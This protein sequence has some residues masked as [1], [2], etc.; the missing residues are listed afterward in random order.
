MSDLQERWDTLLAQEPKLRIRNAAA[1]LETSE[2]QLL[3]LRLGEGVTRLEPRWTD[4]LSELPKLGSVMA[5]T[6]NE[7]AVHEKTGQYDN[8][9]VAG[10]V[11]LVLNH[12]I[13]LRIFL[14]HWRYGFVVHNPDAKGKARDSLQFFN[15]AGQALHKIF[16]TKDS[17]REA[18]AQIK[19]AFTQEDQSCPEFTAPAAPPAEKP[20]AELDVEGFIQAWYALEDTHDFFGLLRKYGVSRTQALTLA[21]DDLA[22]E[23]ETS[24]VRSMLE[25]AAEK[26]VP[27]MAFVGSPGVIQIHTGPI[28]RLLETGPWFNVLDPDFNLHLNEEGVAK[29]WRVRKPTVDGV[30]T[31]LEAFDHEGKNIA[32]F[33]GER[34]PGI[35][36]DGRWRDLI[37]AL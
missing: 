32:M 15:A 3:C 17:D 13:D 36:E 23:V 18:F 21:P 34:K 27:I 37:E 31:S 11:G 26:E 8:I 1:R 30:V 7:Y 33:F 35:P 10:P 29:V 22:V 25:K 12:D 19:A 28:K 9:E 16:L 5:L 14:M 2:A 24:S 4:L 20:E 6:R